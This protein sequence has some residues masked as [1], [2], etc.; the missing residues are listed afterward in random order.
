VSSKT[1]Q[2]QLL[3]SSG[4]LLARSAIRSDGCRARLITELGLIPLSRARRARDTPR[5]MAEDL[6]GC[7]AE[8]L[9]EE[10]P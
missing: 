1:G 5:T 9:A 2:L 7:A 10:R 6:T 3:T 8:R 4:A